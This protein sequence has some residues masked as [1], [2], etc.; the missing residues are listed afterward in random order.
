MVHTVLRYLKPVKHLRE[1]YDPIEESLVVAISRF[2]LGG[3]LPA[4]ANI[5]VP[6]FI[7]EP[8]PYRD[9][10][11][12]ERFT[13]CLKFYFARLSYFV[14]LSIHLNQLDIFSPEKIHVTWQQQ[15]LVN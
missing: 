11:A 2:L 12:L 14:R 8:S 10:P 9:C 5:Y 6:L 15:V 1:S 3:W 7:S 13:I 4:E